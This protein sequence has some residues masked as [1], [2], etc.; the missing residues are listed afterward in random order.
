M[1]LEYLRG[2][3]IS[4]PLCN[5]YFKTT[6]YERIKKFSQI[7][8]FQGLWRFLRDPHGVLKLQHWLF[9]KIYAL[10]HKVQT[11]KCLLIITYHSVMD[12]EKHVLSIGTSA[13]EVLKGR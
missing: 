7:F 6:A 8:S 11:P 12:M 9:K 2:L 13:N 3:D 4:I 10:F 5:A 1:A